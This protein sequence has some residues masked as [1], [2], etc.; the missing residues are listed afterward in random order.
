MA[1][2]NDIDEFDLAVFFNMAE[3][4]DISHLVLEHGYETTFGSSSDSDLDYNEHVMPTVPSLLGSVVFGAL[5]YIISLV[6]TGYTIV[7]A[8]ETV[9]F[10]LSPNTGIAWKVGWIMFLLLVGVFT[11]TLLS[12]NFEG[13]IGIGQPQVPRWL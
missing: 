6:V 7:Q 13:E 3:H 2:I 9:S 11:S 12:L 1:N 10:I 4:Y 8:M 5:I